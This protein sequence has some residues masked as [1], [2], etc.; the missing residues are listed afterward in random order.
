MRQSNEEK[1]GREIR[2]REGNQS[3]ADVEEGIER[4]EKVTNFLLNGYRY[5]STY[6]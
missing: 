5:F 1:Y 3:A 2:M 6:F 4:K